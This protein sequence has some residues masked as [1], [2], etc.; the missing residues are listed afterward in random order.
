MIFSPRFSRANRYVKRNGHVILAT[1]GMIT[2]VVAVVEAIKASPK[3]EEVRKSLEEDATPV[4]K[5]KAYAPVYAETFIFTG[6]SLASTGF[7]MVLSVKAIAGLTAG[8]LALEKNFRN[9]RAKLKEMITE[10]NASDGEKITAE[11]FD[12]RIMGEVYEDAAEKEHPIPSDGEYL[13]YDANSERYF[14]D[15]L[16]HV[17]D[18]EYAFNRNFALRGDA[19]L[20]DF[21]EC[22]DHEEM[23]SIDEGD[24]IGWSTYFLEMDYHHPWVDFEH[25]TKTL[26][27]G[28][29]YIEITTSTP[30][31]RDALI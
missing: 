15:T 28:T 18:A 11:E 12:K 14:T 22:L 25:E 8:Y 13:F 2:S 4:E 17:H 20:N 23:P 6:I 10:V 31:S 1:V 16:L 30:P 24:L 29:E 3:A 26:K 21:Y 7:S 5:V 27:D 9:Y 19:S